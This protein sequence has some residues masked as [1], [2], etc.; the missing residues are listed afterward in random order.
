M[1]R[2]LHV[3]SSLNVGGIEH[4]LL[5]YCVTSLAIGS[6]WTLYVKEIAQEFWQLRPNRLEPGYFIVLYGFLTRPS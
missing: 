4:C 5:R 1:I 3:L 6:R 2:V